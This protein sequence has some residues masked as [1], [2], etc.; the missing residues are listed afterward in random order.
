MPFRLVH[1][2][3]SNHALLIKITQLRGRGIGKFYVK[4]LN[5]ERMI[6]LPKVKN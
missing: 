4:N 1:S 2:E 6:F 3:L 5:I